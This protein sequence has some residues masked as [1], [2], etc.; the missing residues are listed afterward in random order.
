MQITGVASI[1]SDLF[2]H[3]TGGNAGT[4]RHISRSLKPCTPWHFSDPY[5]LPHSK[6]P[7]KVNQE[8]PQHHSIPWHWSVRKMRQCYIAQYISDYI[9]FCAKAKL[10]LDFCQHFFFC[11][12]NHLREKCMHLF[13]TPLARWDKNKNTF[14]ADLQLK[15]SLK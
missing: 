6:L 5:C 1:T 9:W 11:H 7:V 4:I 14:Q 15:T 3:P 13:W 10:L 8:E 2:K 12:F